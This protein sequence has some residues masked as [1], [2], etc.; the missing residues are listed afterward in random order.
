MWEKIRVV[1]TI[2]ELRNKILLTLFFLAVY[3]V[4]WHVPLPI[5][6]PEKMK[7]LLGGALGDILTQILGVD[8][9]PAPGQRLG[10]ARTATERRGKRAK[11]N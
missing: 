8:H 4:G 5:A 9:F 1:F 3:R 7:N 2:P 6:D 10:S 11:E